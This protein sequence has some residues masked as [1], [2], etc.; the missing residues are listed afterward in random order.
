M[1]FQDPSLAAQKAGGSSPKLDVVGGRR[2]FIKALGLGI[3]GTAIMAAGGAKPAIAQ[4][5]TDT[6][7][8]N[9]ALNFEYL[10]A[11][12][13]LRASVGQ[14]L[15][16]AEVSGVGTL[17][18]VSGGRQV[19][20]AT[21]YL[22]NFANELAVDERAHVNTLRAALGSAAIARP[23]IDLGEAFTLA[24]QGAGLIGQGQVFDP[25]ADENSF[26]QAAFI[27]EDVCVTALTGAAPLVQSKQVLAVAAGFLGVEAYQ[28]GAI[29]TFLTSRGFFTQ[30]GAISAARAKLDG[31]GN[32]DQGISDGNTYNITPTDANGLVF[33]RTP[34]E[35]LRIAYLNQ[36][37]TPN[38]FFPMGAN[39]TIR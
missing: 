19:P 33:A 11:E 32:D 5:I 24:A 31:V 28:A 7:I 13:Y 15:T 30:A 18:P 20:F 10:G 37:G 4:A 39:G 2:A 8:V 16:D 27:F 12:F 36:A 9:F 3:A 34:Q 23:Q 29:R 6:D 26:L 17:G 22:A 38:G 25:F 1:T 35:V 14:G 21:R